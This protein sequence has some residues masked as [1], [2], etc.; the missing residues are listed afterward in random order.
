MFSSPFISLVFGY[1]I[2]LS[3]KNE[4]VS[5]VNF[6]IEVGDF[7]H[8]SCMFFRLNGFAADIVITNCDLAVSGEFVQ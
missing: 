4:F 2:E 3:C 6:G 8:N 7:G 1:A 5:S